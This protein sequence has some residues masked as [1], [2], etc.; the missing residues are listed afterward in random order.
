MDYNLNVSQEVEDDMFDVC[1]W[2]EQQRVGLGEEFLNAVD[3]STQILLQNPK[4]Y[5][6]RYKRNIRAYLIHRFP[7]II[8]YLVEKKD[9]NVLAVFNTS[10]DPLIW[11]KRV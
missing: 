6:V 7:Y 1:K 8:L 2:H 4:T 3:D 10:R 5:R 9:V 11:K